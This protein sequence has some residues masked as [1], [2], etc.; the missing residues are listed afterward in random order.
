[1][2]LPNRIPL[3]PLPNVV[4]FPGVPLPLHVFELRYREMIRDA[5]A[6]NSI[7]GM[8][9]LK[10]EWQKD[11]YARPSIF[12]VGCAGRLVSVEPLPDGRSN[13]LLHGI[14]QFTIV[15]E[16]GER[17]YREAEVRW[18]ATEVGA[19]VDADQRRRVT[20]LIE[21][22]LEHAEETPASKLLHDPSLSDELLINFF[23]YALDLPPLEKLG[24]L[25]TPSLRGRAR[26]L[27]EVLEF[28][29]E[30]F[31]LASKPPLGGDRWH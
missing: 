13:I 18:W 20:T 14:R 4:L 16:A 1:M 2:D 26:Q 31:R 12:T 5:Q 28:R 11:Y 21:R 30:E 7:V 15:G 25:E 10:G 8:V 24:L 27:C 17:A 29:L 23:S 9:L 3:F 19:S 22:F 6:G